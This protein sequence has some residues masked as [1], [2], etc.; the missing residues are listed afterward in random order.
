MIRTASIAEI[1]RFYLRSFK[2]RF[3]DHRSEFTEIKRHVRAGDVVCDVGANKG[4]FT[5]WLS[6]WCGKGGR[7]V[8]FEPQRELAHRLGANCSA[9][10]L[11]N[12]TVEAKAV[13]STSGAREFYV[14][15]GHQPGASLNQPLSPDFSS[16]TVPAVS[17]DDYFRPD[18]RVSLLKVDV[19]GAELGVFLGAKRILGEHKPVLIFECE[20]RHLA[21][22]TVDDVFGH[23]RSLGYT[24]RFFTRTGLQPIS[25]FDL[26]VHQRRE[27][28]W[29][30]K[31][32][33]YCNNFIF[34]TEG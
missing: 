33:D 17:L 28:E 25:A 6:R 20:A 23:L 13:D 7:V 5:F 18:E 22:K 30:W 4:S 8:A 12:V 34:T 16:L 10:G 21:G 3:R 11:S 2:A 1:S 26:A 24:G 15:L 27:G 19:E 14:P 31:E 29:F 9:C 32:K